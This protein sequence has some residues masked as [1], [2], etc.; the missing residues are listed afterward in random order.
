MNKKNVSFKQIF[1]SLF[2]NSLLLSLLVPTL[3]PAKNL[4]Y[5]GDFENGLAGWTTEHWWYEAKI[6]GKG[7]GISRIE[8]DENVSKSGMKSLKIVGK[9][10]RGIAMQVLQL[11][12]GK[13][14]VKGYIKCENL[15]NAQ[16]SI[17]LE[18][19]DKDGKW[20]EGIT[21][22][23][24][25]GTADWTFIEKE[26]DFPPQTVWVHFD[27][28]TSSPNDGIAWFD[29]IE[30]LP[31]TTPARIP[32]PTISS[33]PSDFG[34][35]SLAWEVDD[36]SG[37]REYEIFVEPRPF[38]SIKN[39]S[40]KTV[41]GFLTRQSIIPV[42]RSLKSVYVAVVPVMVD[43]R[44]LTEVK[45]IKMDIRDTKA[46]APVE[47][48]VA[49]S[50]HKPDHLF[51]RWN[52]NTLDSDIKSFK[53]M[54][55]T[56]KGREI[57]LRQIPANQRLL[58]L[59]RASLPKDAKEIALVAVDYAGN[60]SSPSWQAIPALIPSGNLPLDFWVA[61]PLDNIFRDTPKPVDVSKRIK[62]YSARNER[63]CS[64]VVLLSSTSLKG[65][66][67]EPSPLV[68]EDGKSVISEGNISLNFVGYI[69]VEKN[70]T[71][72]PVEE[73][74]RQAP[75]DFPDPLLEDWQIDLAPNQN[76]PF[77]ISV[78][79]PKNAK[80]GIYKGE[81]FVVSNE[82]YLSIPIE[83]EVFPVTLPDELPIF[84][85]NWFNTSAIARFHN[86]TEWSEDFW[87]MLRLYAR[88]MRRGH[89]N[90][91]LTPLS[92]IKIWREENGSF[93]F[94]FS[95]FDRW[96]QLFFDEGFKRIELSHL[97]GRTT[98]DWECPTFTLS[99]RTATDRL[100]GEQVEVGLDVF[101]P[102]LQKHLE[103][104]GWRDKTL[105]HI[106]DE[107][108]MVNVASWREQSAF[109]HRYAP[110]LKR[111]DAI[112]VPA[113]E[114][115]GYL[116]VLVPQLN[117]LVEWLEGYKEAQR[118]GYE[119][120][121]YTAWVPQGKFLNRLLDYPVIKSRLLPWCGFLYGVTGWLHW[122]LNFWTDKELR[123][124]G[125]APGDNWILYPGKFG[126]RSSLRWEAMRDGF[127][128]F[129]LLSML[130]RDKAEPF[131]QAIIRSATDY[132]KSPRRL[133]EI[134]LQILRALAKR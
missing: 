48:F 28:L 71:A 47:F 128:D 126:P 3:L 56:T 5:N 123:D 13:Y 24:V 72:T 115:D 35:I 83:L 74:A 18:F 94:D 103:E 27:L 89:Q 60:E 90:V 85:T 127:E 69:Y 86:L 10:N 114:V 118:K 76:Q 68:S 51:L 131:L 125:F 30:L 133:E 124:M 58:L 39:L 134:R 26:I 70:S 6:D 52:P 63:E 53:L 96:V 102:A 101:L 77:L 73:L 64:Q 84:V 37:I 44:K 2:L 80:P 34:E 36:P 75:A 62:L 105:M 117:Y 16:A 120:W 29:G 88:E 43:G 111:I 1:G 14:I 22:G 7:T 65:V 87:K 25:S 61:S 129:A 40:P 108:I 130:G 92:L 31:A 12:P 79:V 104:K 99:P 97:G 95:D 67:L 93:T 121:F 122:G 11:P 91:V 81:V 50:A 38:Q 107:P 113:P 42:E 23:S 78:F 41:V 54:I 45:P 4:L 98:G 21:A 32:Q 112:H 82:G 132:E 106:A 33:L 66:W 49:S 119:L 116:E 17:L 109:A 8:L 110:L 20:F 100:S 55:R 9:G 59:P 15:G 19:L 57:A 46:P